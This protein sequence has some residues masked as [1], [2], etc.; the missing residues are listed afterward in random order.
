MIIA[1]AGRRIDAP[2]TTV[3]RFP[4]RNSAA[5]RE[6]IRR[7]FTERQ[8][9]ALVCSA[10]CGADLLALDV[11]GELGIARHIVLPFAKQRFR[12]ASVIDRPGEWGGLFD[13]IT[14]EVEAAGNLVILHDEREDDAI[15]A[16]ANRVILD[17]AQSLARQHSQDK[18]G[19]PANDILAVIVWEGQTRGEGD[20]TAD[21]V[22]EARARAIPVAEIL[23]I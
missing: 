2:D 13:R 1:L 15:F 8:A 5:V 16:I 19:P 22:D 20:L 3:S 18:S 6:N 7:L 10:A 21:F 17:E 23:T 4:L 12:S 14:G 11:A 9:T